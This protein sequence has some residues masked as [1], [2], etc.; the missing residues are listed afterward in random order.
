MS[1][2][3]NIHRIVA[4]S[5]LFT[6]VTIANRR[7]YGD[8][9]ANLGAVSEALRRIEDRLPSD[10]RVTSIKDKSSTAFDS[11]PLVPTLKIAR[12]GY[13]RILSD[14]QDYTCVMIKR[15]LVNGRLNGPETIFAKVRHQQVEDG[16][17]VSPF[18]VYL[19]FQAPDSI[20]NREVLFVRKGGNEKILV[21]NGGKRLGFLTLSL[22]PNGPIAMSGNRYPIT[23]FGIKRL[24][25]RM[26]LL[27]ERELQHQECDV[28]IRDKVSFSD[29]VCR[30]IEVKHPIKREHFEY[31]LVRIYIDN[32]LRVPI[33]FESYDWPKDGSEAPVL[34]EEYTYRDLKLNVG[35]TK[36]D[37][38]RNN[39]AYGFR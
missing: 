5:L 14:V 6:L 17:V 9:P 11:H 27:G 2:K 13:Q 36:T 29:H 33:R 21:K 15:E 22:N 7:V 26:I 1:E 25:E 28:E 18:S 16:R 8:D 10:L 38:Q 23:E 4:V 39:P 20:Q 30:C 19:K 34:M 24:I 37:F 3:T 31:H 32:E 35:L 12:D